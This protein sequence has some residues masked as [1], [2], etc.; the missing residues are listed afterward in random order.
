M[1]LAYA[2]FCSDLA[3]IVCI[4]CS[5][6]R[7]HGITE[8]GVCPVGA[9]FNSQLV[10]VSREKIACHHHV[11]SPSGERVLLKLNEPA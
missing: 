5:R 7:D 2:E 10:E 1:S 8:D 6:G 11:S 3:R 4:G 9:Y